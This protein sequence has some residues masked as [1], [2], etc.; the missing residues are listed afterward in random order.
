[1]CE[2]FTASFDISDHKHVKLLPILVRYFQGYDLE[3]P[4]KNELLTFVKISGET[5]D[6]ISM[7]MMKAVA[8]YDLR[9][10]GSR[11]ITR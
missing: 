7:Q 2:I 4:A 11:V 5:V 3:N 6:I 1:M 10:K 8:N 9:D